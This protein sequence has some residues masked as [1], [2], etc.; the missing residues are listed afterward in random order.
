MLFALLLTLT[1][2][3]LARVGR[4][5]DALCHDLGAGVAAVLAMLLVLRDHG[6]G[7]LI[8]PVAAGAGFLVNR[9]WRQPGFPRT[10]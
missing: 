6:M 1:S 8:F 4:W 10:E 3:W 5:L 2:E 9:R 7:M